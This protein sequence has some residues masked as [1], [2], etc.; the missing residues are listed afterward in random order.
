MI[1]VESARTRIW[2][3]PAALYSFSPASVGAQTVR[4]D[5]AVPIPGMRLEHRRQKIENKMKNG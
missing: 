1:A 4:S 3:N 2:G 5:K